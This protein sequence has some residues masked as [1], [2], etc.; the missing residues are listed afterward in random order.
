MGQPQISKMDNDSGWWVVLSKSSSGGNTG[1]I[2]DGHFAYGGDTLTFGST[3]AIPPKSSD[4]NRL[5]VQTTTGSYRI[6]ANENADGTYTVKLKGS[7][8]N[9][10]AAILQTLTANA[11]Q[12]Y[13]LEISS[14]GAPSLSNA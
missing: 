9:A 2:S 10:E 13:E 6:W 3:L 4:D 11:G 7:V 8:A 14:G 5:F 1:G 12:E